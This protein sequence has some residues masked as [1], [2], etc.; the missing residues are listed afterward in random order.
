[1]SY[2]L[3]VGDKVEIIGITLV[4]CECNVKIS[5]VAKVISVYE[6]EQ[7]WYFCTNPNWRVDK[8]IMKHNQLKKL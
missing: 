5:D 6:S 4:D 3:K 8:L 7:G 1:M 2:H